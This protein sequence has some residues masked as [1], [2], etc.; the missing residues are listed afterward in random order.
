VT[1]GDELDPGEQLERRHEAEDAD[2]AV[3]PVWQTKA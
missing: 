2:E 3:Q 1:A